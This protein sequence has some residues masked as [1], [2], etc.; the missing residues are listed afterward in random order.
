MSHVTSDLAFPH[1]FDHI[2]VA[3]AAFPE[4]SLYTTS[5]LEMIIASQDYNHG[6]TDKFVLP[7]EASIACSP[8]PQIETNTKSKNV[9]EKILQVRTDCADFYAL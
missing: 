3:S 7:V 2:H 5:P 6:Q 1:T 4:R 9:S 8:F